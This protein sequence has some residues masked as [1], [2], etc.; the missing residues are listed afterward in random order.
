MKVLL[1]V[2]RYQLTNKPNYQYLFPLGLGYIAAVLK[3]AGHEL[4]AINLNHIPGTITALLTE[5][6]DSKAYDVVMTGHM[7]I[8]YSIVQ[9]IVDVSKGHPTKPKTVVG[10]FVITP[11]PAL[12]LESLGADYVCIGE[13]EQTIVELIE[14]IEKKSDPALVNGIGYLNSKGEAVITKEREAISNL[15][16]LPFPDFEELD[17]ETYLQH[18]CSNMLQGYMTS[19]APKIYPLIASRDCPYKCTFCYQPA[20]YR[21]RSLDNV[22][23]ELRQQI[24]KYHIDTILLYDDLFSINKPRLFEFCKRI[25]ELRAEI[26]WDVKWFC[27]LTVCN[28]DDHMLK[29]LREAGCFAISFGFESM[30][31]TVLRSMKKP[32][33]VQMINN[34]FTL[35]MKHD[36]VIIANFIFGDPAETLATANETLQYWRDNCK[37]QVNLGFIQPYPGSSIYGQCV[38]KGLIKD[39]LSFIK[40]DIGIGQI[41]TLYNI[42]NNMSDDEFQWLRQ[43]V[44]RN[45]AKHNNF[46]V[47]SLKKKKE[48]RYSLKLKCHFCRESIS[49]DNFYIKR[50]ANF[51]WQMNC[52]TCGKKFY[53]VSRLKK[54]LYKNY[55]L[56][57]P[58]FNFIV[59]KKTQLMKS[60]TH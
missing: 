40:N 39:K 56:L 26:S 13:A 29:T 4:E 43:E 44:D 15:D 47:P 2:P 10:G 22:F 5:R 55:S 49:F 42:T 19:D 20:T 53:A 51:T 25:N 32:A 46:V 3:R 48:N 27:Q 17:Y 59:N 52:P 16:S 21:T 54:I 7:G 38:E 35:A 37:G 30:S 24:K 18:T 1:V 6:L 9:T 57:N 11:E 33:T 28:L 34:V 60:L 41:P 14:C 36:I 31:P 50:M 45:F 12:M 8:G 58:V 23:D